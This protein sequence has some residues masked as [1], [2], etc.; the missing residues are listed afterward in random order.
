M[1]LYINAIAHYI[2]EVV[3]P[4]SHFKKLNGLD[5]EW[6]YSRTGIKT[7][8]KVT[9]GENTNTMAL[10]AVE[11]AV[12]KLPY[13]I[14]EVDLIVAATYSPYDTVATPAHAI[15]SRYSIPN[16]KCV[17]VSSACSS[18][19]NAMEI[20]EGYMKMGKASKALVVASE[21]N[22]KY[23][24]ETD[25]QSGHLWGDGAVAVFISGE[26]C[27]DAD[28]EILSIYTRGLGHIGKAMEAVHLHPQDGGISMPEGKDV[29][30][31]ACNY[32]VEALQKAGESC[33]KTIQDL[34]HI[35]PHQAN[36][37]I[38]RNIAKQ[39]DIPEDRFM[40]TIEGWGNTGC[41]SCMITLSE[42][43][44]RIQKNDLVGLTVF[45]GG[46]SCGALLLQY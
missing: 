28:A 30:I 14:S 38:I 22:T 41:P 10:N 45:G 11:K 25:P 4:N 20:V 24:N 39:H 21:H 43:S 42:H 6:I 33:G 44:N 29:F 17:C 40:V 8:S 3:V 19:I 7:R 31:N 32:M 27:Q 2:P 16:A 5:D 36:L 35:A 9:D 26:R 37:R 15:Q 12:G 46:Y 1:N 13:D 34:N 23:A 18:F